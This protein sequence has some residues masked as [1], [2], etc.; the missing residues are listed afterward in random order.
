MAEHLQIGFVIVFRG[1]KIIPLKFKK[2][3][4]ILRN[5]FFM[6]HEIFKKDK[7]DPLLFI[8]LFILSY[9]RITCY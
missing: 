1:K 4:F 3:K 5:L 8:Y 7:D 9:E 2:F 6:F